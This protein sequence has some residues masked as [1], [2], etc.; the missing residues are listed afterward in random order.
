[1]TQSDLPD[2]RFTLTNWVHTAAVLVAG[3]TAMQN[4]WRFT[5]VL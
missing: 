2:G 5:N 1:M 4:L 3:P